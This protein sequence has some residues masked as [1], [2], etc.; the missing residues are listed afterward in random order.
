MAYVVRPGQKVP[1]T[2]WIM[3]L[4]ADASTCLIE[5]EDGKVVKAPQSE[6]WALG[7][8]E[9]AVTEHY[10]RKGARVATLG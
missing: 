1:R 6:R 4:F 7:Q 5:V 9:Q 3:I 8:P 10:R 2:K